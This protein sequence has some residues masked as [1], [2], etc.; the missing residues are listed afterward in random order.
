MARHRAEHETV[1]IGREPAAAADAQHVVVVEF[2]LADR[3]AEF[4]PL[5]PFDLDRRHREKQRA[6]KIGLGA[7]A[8]LR[9]RFFGGHFGQPLGQVRSR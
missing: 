9:E 3:A 5:R 2:G 6:G 1:M 8:G 7:D 4:E